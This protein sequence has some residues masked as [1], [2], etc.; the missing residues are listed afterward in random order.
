MHGGKTKLKLSLCWGDNGAGCR[1]QRSPFTFSAWPKI[2]HRQSVQSPPLSFSRSPSCTRDQLNIYWGSSR[3]G[4]L[5][6]LPSP[7]GGQLAFPAEKA[8]QLLTHQLAIRDTGSEGPTANPASLTLWV[9]WWKLRHALTCWYGGEI[10]HVCPFLLPHLLPPA[11]SP[12]NAL[13]MPWLLPC[14][15]NHSLSY[16]PIH[17]AAVQ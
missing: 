7:A 8:A 17:W 3:P 13:S 6:R 2:A 10:H 4:C 15:M 9:T 12:P 14:H 11:P 5:T 16:K 1:G